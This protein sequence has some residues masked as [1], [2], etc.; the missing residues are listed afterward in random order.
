MRYSEIVGAMML[1]MMAMPAIAAPAVS[2]SPRNASYISSAA[3]SLS[4]PPR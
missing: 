4:T 3:H 2:A 1:S